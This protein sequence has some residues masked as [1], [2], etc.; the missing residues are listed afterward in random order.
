MINATKIANIPG[1]LI[2]FISCT[3]N[4]YQI[5]KSKNEDK[6]L[7][8]CYLDFHILFRE[9]ALAEIISSYLNEMQVSILTEK[10]Y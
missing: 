10:L 5:M 6:S 7:I 2:G 3:M 4:L 8:N 9:K 1:D